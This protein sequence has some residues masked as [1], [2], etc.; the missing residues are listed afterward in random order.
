MYE[1]ARLART[2]LEVEAE[3]LVGRLIVIAG[4]PDAMVQIARMG[5]GEEPQVQYDMEKVE[6]VFGAQRAAKLRT[7][8]SNATAWL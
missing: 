5:E 1:A 3:A 6:K 8:V 4:P 2:H 7:A